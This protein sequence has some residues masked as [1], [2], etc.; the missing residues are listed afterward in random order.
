MDMLT[1]DVGRRVYLKIVLRVKV[2]DEVS[3]VI[4]DAVVGVR[5]EEKRFR[6]FRAVF[7]SSNVR[8]ERENTR[9]R[10][11]PAG[12]VQFHVKLKRGC[13]VN[14]RDSFGIAIIVNARIGKRSTGLSRQS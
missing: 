9:L 5:T 2:R 7:D 10:V 11:V 14:S 6:R 12:L 3:V 4:R 13:L 1:D 8:P